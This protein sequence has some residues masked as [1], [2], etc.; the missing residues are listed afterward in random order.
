MIQREYLLRLKA[1]VVGRLEVGSIYLEQVLMIPYIYLVVMVTQAV[2]S[3]YIGRWHIDVK[4]LKV[5]WV[6][7]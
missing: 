3:G 5:R 2:S 7:T 1:Q 4:I 6:E